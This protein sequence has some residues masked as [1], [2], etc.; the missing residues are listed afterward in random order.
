ME[1]APAVRDWE[2]LMKELQVCGASRLLPDTSLVFC[3]AVP[4][5]WVWGGSWAR[6]EAV[7][8]LWWLYQWLGFNYGLGMNPAVGAAARAGWLALD[9]WEPASMGCVD[10]LPWCWGSAD[11]PPLTGARQDPQCFAGL[12]SSLLIVHIPEIALVLLYA[13]FL[14]LVSPLPPV[15]SDG[16]E[17]R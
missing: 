15:S 13:Y 9:C 7:V 3:S 12:S 16:W 2:L 10:P 14:S 5:S 4:P 11:P 17:L 6:A 8:H 1:A